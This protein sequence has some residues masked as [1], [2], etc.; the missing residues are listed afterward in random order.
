MTPDAEKKPEDWVQVDADTHYTSVQY[1]NPARLAS[2]GYQL[3]Y[4]YQHFPG[5]RVLEVG[6]GT[7][8]AAELMTRIGCTVST[9]DVDAK[10]APTVVGSVTDIPLEDGAYDAFVCCQVLEHISWSDAKRALA[11]L[12]RVTSLGGVLSVPTVRPRLGV[13]LYPF[14]RNTRTVMLPVPWPASRKLHVPGEHQWELG[15]GVSLRQLRQA[16][17]DA[18]FEIAEERQPIENPFHHFFVLKPKQ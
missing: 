15:I 10:L 6:V 12:R 17:H 3:R 13:R 7:G 4:V 18:G 9:L 2:I 5:S 11:E 1:L 16:I 8:L 14:L